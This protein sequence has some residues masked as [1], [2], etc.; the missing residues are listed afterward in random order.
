MMIFLLDRYEAIFQPRQFDNFYIYPPLLRSLNPLET[1][2]GLMRGKFGSGHVNVCPKKKPSLVECDGQIHV[3][4]ESNRGVLI[5]ATGVQLYDLLLFRVASN[6]IR[7]MQG[8]SVCICCFADALTAREFWI[9]HMSASFSLTYVP[10]S[11]F[12]LPL[13]QCISRTTWF[14]YLLDSCVFLYE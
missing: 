3:E 12:G 14:S 10:S 6:P 8:K 1:K 13:Y 4:E 7:L 2:P 5:A 11:G 9:G